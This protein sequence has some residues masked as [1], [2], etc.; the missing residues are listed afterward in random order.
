MKKEESS[1]G[2]TW[3]L[4]FGLGL[5]FGL[6]LRKIHL[7]PAHSH[8]ERRFSAC[9]IQKR[10]G[11]GAEGEGGPGATITVSPALAN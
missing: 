6:W 8:S 5:M 1:G 4:M 7:N 10:V 3:E 2:L 9:R 11:S